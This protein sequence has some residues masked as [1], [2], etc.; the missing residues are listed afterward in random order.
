M[1]GI[2]VDPTY[3][4]IGCGRLEEATFRP[5]L[6]PL[7]LTRDTLRYRP[8]AKARQRAGRSQFELVAGTGVDHNLRS[9]PAKMVAGA[10]T[11]LNLLFRTAA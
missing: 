2:E 3:C 4:E 9:T 5:Q 7:D 11:H 10:C 8:K 6:L 1:L